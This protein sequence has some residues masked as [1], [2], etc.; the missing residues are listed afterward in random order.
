[1]LYSLSP[2]EAEKHYYDQ[3]VNYFA[4]LRKRL[5]AGTIS[6]KFYDDETSR[7]M[8]ELEDPDNLLAKAGDFEF[9]RF[10]ND[11]AIRTGSAVG[12][13]TAT[14]LNSTGKA[15]SA[16]IEAGVKESV[17]ASGYGTLFLLALV[18]IGLY[19]Y[20]KIK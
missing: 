19:V 2:D 11:V 20:I 12:T 15:L 5:S 8:G 16:G 7:F 13:A 3:K 1:M 4:K 18:G 10:F 6:Q 17:V 9:Q 14:V